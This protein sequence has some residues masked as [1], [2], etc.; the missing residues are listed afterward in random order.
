[1]KVLIADDDAV[2]L[3]HLG[4][5]LRKWGYEV[6]TVSD[7]LQAWQKLREPGGPELAVLDW[8]MPGMDGLEICQQARELSGVRPLHILLLTSR[9]NRQDLVSGLESG[10]YDYVVKPFDPTEL[11]ARIHVGVRM[12][13]LQRSLADRVR[14][15]EG[16]LKNV[17]QLQ[18]LLPICCYCKKV[19][20]DQNYWQRVESYITEHSEAVVSHSICPEC[21][22]TVAQAEVEK[23]QPECSS[24]EVVDA[25][26]VLALVEGDV[27]LL[28]EMVAVFLK[29]LPKLLSNLRDALSRG[30]ARL[31]ESAAHALKSSLTNFSA[32]TAME[33]A[34]RL[35]KMGRQGDF[36]QGSLA[37]RT[38]EEEIDRVKA[39]FID[40]GWVK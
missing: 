6:V 37:F 21:F 18:G 38:V 31:V 32:R 17:K 20:N 3:T 14:D 26:S 29:D 28:R 4:A 22:A 25:A 33:T 7:G 12:I 1:M 39:L 40:L 5:S 35:E 27:E 24:S 19:R 15:L 13:E 34:L 16:A 10:A 9:A 2:S 36:T 8:M 30:D 11:R 23:P